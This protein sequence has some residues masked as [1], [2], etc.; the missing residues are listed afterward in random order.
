[1]VVFEGYLSRLLCFSWS[2][3]PMPLLLFRP[4]FILMSHFKMAA[5]KYHNHTESKI[6]SK[7]S[8]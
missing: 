6:V 3:N 7:Q 4:Q 8:Q 5:E 2:A 1:M